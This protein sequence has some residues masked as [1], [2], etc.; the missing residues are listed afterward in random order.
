MDLKALH[1]FDLVVRLHVVG[2]FGTPIR[3]LLTAITFEDVERER[4]VVVENVGP[5]LPDE[6]CRDAVWL[7]W[8][9]V[10]QIQRLFPVAVVGEAVRLPCGGRVDER[11]V[12]RV[13]EVKTCEDV[14]GA[15][16][17]CALQGCDVVGHANDVRL[18][19][20]ACEQARNREY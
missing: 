15:R 14:T 20:D 6:L 3:Y 9:G 5:V 7:G 18:R 10:I 8:I 11:V 13:V 2:V 17:P 19:R 16:A 12:D 1:V 4:I